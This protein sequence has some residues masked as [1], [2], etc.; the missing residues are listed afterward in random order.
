MSAML[1]PPLEDEKAET[2]ACLGHCVQPEE[3]AR[4]QDSKV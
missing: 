1:S 2:T 3:A 4:G